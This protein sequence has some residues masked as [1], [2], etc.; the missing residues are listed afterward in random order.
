[1]EEGEKEKKRALGT[2]LTELFHIDESPD[3]NGAFTS[4]NGNEG[5]NYGRE[6]GM[7][8]ET[9]GMGGRGRGFVGLLS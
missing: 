8:G 9:G 1:M 5:G 2:V 3:G 6:R 4:N 7:K